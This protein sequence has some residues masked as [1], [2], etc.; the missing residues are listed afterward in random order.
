MCELAR[1]Y[2]YC[3]FVR[4]TYIY[5]RL[6]DTRGENCHESRYQRAYIR[7]E[8]ARRWPLIW[9]NEICDGHWGLAGGGG[10]K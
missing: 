2:L 8:R 10:K 3:T 6:D 7:A 9:V 1:V 5:G 4:L